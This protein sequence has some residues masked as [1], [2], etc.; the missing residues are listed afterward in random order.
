MSNGD[1]TKQ[2]ADREKKDS[3][4]DK[5]RRLIKNLK[6]GYLPFAIIV[7]IQFIFI[8]MQCTQNSSY[9]RQMKMNYL[10]TYLVEQK[11]TKQDRK[12]DA[13][14]MVLKVALDYQPKLNERL[15]CEVAEDIFNKG[16]SIY[17]TPTEEWILLFSHEGEWKRT[18]LSYAFARGPGQIMPG[19]GEFVAKALG[20]KWSGV[21]TLYNY[22]H[23][24]HISMKWY[25]HL[26]SRYKEPEYYLTA[27]CWGEKEMGSF[28]GVD[29]KGELVKTKKIT[30]KY[31]DYLKK[32]MRTKRHV[33]KILG[34]KIIIEGLEE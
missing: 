20:I 33:E 14:E 34:K 11:I 7:F 31:R 8:G 16:E 23:N 12:R 4:I 30:G 5:S 18:A 17:N 3:I 19:V 15:L 27:Y 24:I 22:K 29:S 2:L 6:F 9:R 10:S 13:M 32:Y 1:G 21:Q 25:Y 26:K 28:C